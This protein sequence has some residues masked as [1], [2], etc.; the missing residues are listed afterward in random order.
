MVSKKISKKDIEGFLSAFIYNAYG[1]TSVDNVA[2]I[3]FSNDNYV[4]KK[5]NHRVRGNPPP[6]EVNGEIDKY[7]VSS[8]LI[9]NGETEK[10]LRDLEDKVFAGPVKIY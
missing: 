4:A 8:E 9:H 2:S 7:E 10:V 6:P 5:L 3:V 1:G